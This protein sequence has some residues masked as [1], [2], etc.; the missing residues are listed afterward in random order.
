MLLKMNPSINDDD[1]FEFV[2]KMLKRTFFQYTFTRKNIERPAAYICDEFHR[3]IT[4]D[5]LSG[6]QHYL[7]R[8]R[9]FNA[10]CLLASQ[11]IQSIRE[12]AKNQSGNDESDAIEII[13]NNTA[14]KYFFRTTDVK[15]QDYL[16]RLVPQPIDK[17]MRSVAEIR[18]LSTLQ[19]GQCYAFFSN[20]DWT[21]QQIDLDA[22]ETRSKLFLSL[23]SETS[24]QADFKDVEMAFN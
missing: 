8:C 17:N 13:L 2:G 15:T 21:L 4:V 11:S 22:I 20:G 16:E 14:N 24:K 19:Q 3:F 9:S 1:G 23:I 10:L 12:S 5:R 6:E 18:R 7:N